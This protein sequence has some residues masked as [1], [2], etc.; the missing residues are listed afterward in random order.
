MMIAR[1]M[2]KLVMNYVIYCIYWCLY[3]DAIENKPP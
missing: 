1:K 3:E 2:A